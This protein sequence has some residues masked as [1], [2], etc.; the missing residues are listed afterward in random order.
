[1]YLG[2]IVAVGMNSN[3]KAVGMYRVSSRSFPNRET[4]KQGETVS[5]MPREGFEDDLKKSPYI[6]YNCVRTAGKYAIVSNGSHTDPIAEKIAMGLPPRDAL[7]LS[8]LAMDYEKDDYDTPRI[9]AV[10]QQ[11]CST[12]WLGIVRKDGVMVRAF[13]LEPGKAYYLSTYEKNTP[14]DENADS[15]FEA[16]T[17][18]AACSY[19]IREGVFSEFEHPVTAAAVVAAGTDFDIATEVV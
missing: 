14:R 9:A 12:A 17:A 19:S 2:R 11:E 3:G 4:R 18:Q 1:M 5:V 8:L 16:L 6:A 15:A 10:I 7:T 13:K